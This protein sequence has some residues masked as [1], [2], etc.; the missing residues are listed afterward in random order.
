M[1]GA[2]ELVRL[3]ETAKRGVGNYFVGPVGKRAVRIG[4]QR[5]VLVCEQK[6]RSY[7]INPQAITV[8]GGKLAR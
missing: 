5:P 8:F 2:G 1:E 4:Q 7:G 3:E 6:A